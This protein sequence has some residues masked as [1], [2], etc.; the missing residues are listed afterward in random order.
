MLAVEIGQRLVGQGHPC[1]IIAEAGANHDG[2]LSQARALID[3]AAE[4][5]ADAV[6][7]QVYRAH[8]LYVKDAGMSDY[9]K[10]PRSIY[11]I[12]KEMEVPYEWLPELARHAEEQDLYFIATAFDEE[13]AD[14]V[15]PYVQVHKIASYEMTHLPLVQ[16]I[17]G[18]GK[19]TLMS[20]GTTSLD[21]VAEAVAAFR[22]AGNDQLILNQC[23]ASYPAPLDALN[24][25]AVTTLR[26]RFDVPVGLSDHSQ[27]PLVGPMAA[28]ALGAC[29]IEKHFTLSR[30][31][32]GPDHPFAVE[33]AELRLM[34]QKIR[35]LEAALGTG[36]KVPQEA[37]RELRQFA[38]RSIFAIASIAEG[39]E[40][41][42]HNIGVLR[43]GKRGAGMEPQAYP[44]L[45]GR[46]AAKAI[47]A[48]A[49]LAEEDVK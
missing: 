7:F 33:P 42:P 17:A 1:F 36:E 49:L 11:D 24:V 45:L 29:T 27:D 22:E 25:R 16:Y 18:K 48:Q 20:T 41:S 31:L 5:G 39:E 12:I 10:S 32:P 14:Q 23:T 21:E 46:R 2:R 13:S 3:I 47:P 4:A 9:L 38:R 6:K 35:Q 30:H 40:L 28:V 37:E 44:S 15:D 26:D 43:H 19:P 8:R 34:V